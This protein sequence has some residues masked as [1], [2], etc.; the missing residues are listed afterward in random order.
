M[1][2]NA[3][4]LVAFTCVLPSL[5]SPAPLLNHFNLTREIKDRY[6][7]KLKP[8]VPISSV[9][10]KTIHEYQLINGFSAKL[11]EAE[12]YELRKNPDVEYLAED[13]LVK[14]T[15][16]E[17]QHDASWGLARLCTVDRLADQ[18]AKF[19]R[20][21]YSKQ[22]C[23]TDY[24]NV[25]NANFTFTFDSSAGEGCDIYVLDTGV[26]LE[27]EEFGGRAVWGA[28]FAEGSADD[29]VNGHGTHCAGT[30]AGSRFG[31]AK[32][33]SIIS[34]KVLDDGGS[35]ATSDTVAG[36]D[37][38][39]RNFVANG[40]RPSIVSMSLGSRTY[41]PVDNAVAAAAAGNEGV[42][43]SSVSPARAPSAVTVGSTDITDSLYISSNFGCV[44][45][46]FAPGADVISASPAC[47]N[48]FIALTGT[49]M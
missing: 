10:N 41:P 29:D 31:V 11:D 34:V 28:T 18:N 39:W 17:T 8:G 9:C 15:A 26:Y 46:I 47:R 7:V 32:R 24:L 36:M 33:A 43:A 20:L 4:F 21:S 5:T 45:D 1:R 12:V 48:G 25:S 22:N 6:I 42:D 2:V 40:F 49:S 14:A 27:H 35:G 38:A 37:W 30:A 3:I 19:V 44:V 16:V 13:I 23:L